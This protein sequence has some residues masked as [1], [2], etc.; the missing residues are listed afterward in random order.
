MAT[1]TGEEATRGP[2]DAHPVWTVLLDR[3]DAIADSITLTLFEQDPWWDRRGDATLRADVRESTRRH[4]RRGLEAL[5]G[6]SAPGEEPQHVWRDTARRRARQGVP[7]EVVLGSYTFGT[8]VLWE[9]LLERRGQPGIDDTDLLQAGQGVWHALEVQ[10]AVFI[11]AYRQ[12]E[13]RLARQD[14]LR[15]GQV[16]DGLLD[17]RAGDPLVVEDAREVLGVG[18]DQPLLCVVALGEGSALPL[19]RLEERLEAAGAASHWHVHHGRAVGLV[20]L[21]D[22]PGGIAAVRAAIGAGATGPVGTARAG[23]LAGFA[24]AH[25]LAVRVVE[26]LPRSGRDVADV[27]ERLPELLVAGS[28]EVSARLLETALG[29]LLALPEHSRV[30]LLTT[31]DALLRHDN[32][33][34]HAAEQLICHRNTVLYRREQLERLSGR[35]LADPRDRLLLTLAMLRLRASAEAQSFGPPAT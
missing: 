13:G 34:K 27:T 22:A 3:A 11:R 10:N 33:P 35:S 29:G 30:V 15:R 32:S 8:R 28:P 23:G 20:P 24:T 5:A 12:E 17:G 1:S 31:L 18:P 6:L 21:G 4:I 25:Q 2:R 19:R 9:A 26:G 7:M 16:I 14:H